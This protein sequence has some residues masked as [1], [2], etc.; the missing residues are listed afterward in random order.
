MT[1]PAK[2]IVSVTPSVL[3]AAGQGLEMNGVILTQ[4]PQVPYAAMQPFS[5]A[6][7][8]SEYFG[9]SSQEAALAQNYFAGFSGSNIKPGRL[10]FTQYNEEAVGAYLRGGDARGYSLAQLQAL[11]G[12]LTV[13][14]DGATRTAPSINLSGASS[15]SNAASIIQTALFATDPTEATASECTISGTTM[16][17]GGTITGTVEVGQTVTGSG[18]TANTIILSQISGTPGGAG[19]Y[20]VSQTQTVGSPTAFTMTA[21]DG[22]V[23]FDS[24]SGGFVVSSGITGEPSTIGFATGTIAAA[25]FLT[26]ATG[27]V[28]SQGA[29]AASPAEFMSMLTGISQ[30][31]ATFMTAFDPD[32][33]SGNAVKKAFADWNSLQ[34]NRWCYVCWDNDTSPLN[35]VP[36]SASLG[37]LL[38]DNA[39]SG[40]VLIYDDAT[41]AKKAAFVCGTIASIDFEQLNGRITLS[42]KHQAGLEQTLLSETEAQNLIDNHY[43]FYSEYATA[44]DEFIWFYPGQ[45][46][47]EY[48]WA[49]AY[50]NQIAMNNDFQLS[51]MLLLDQVKAVPYNAAGRQLIEAAVQGTINKYLNFGAFSPGVN[52][53]PLQIA[54]VNNAAGVDLES[55]LYTQGYYFQVLPASPEAR[56]RRTT[57]PC[58]FWYC[59]AG[60]VQQINLASIM[61]Q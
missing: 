43:N 14:I 19:D 7:D 38:A 9:P 4:N 6:A 16:T 15:F 27:A 41:D 2:A 1:I 55:V 49:D 45:I 61:L 60:A 23:T 47:G 57:P 5:S 52:L 54:E 37:Q 3:A 39:S 51:L 44:N 33:G 11:T 28:T 29:D 42:F 10:Y 50:V 8:V 26:A 53:S 22:T 13:V 48:A 36:A 56:A 30:N 58:T 25:L 59:D 31:W 12:S 32:G 35:T 18:V 34:N 24:V 17:V 46:M 40:T 21:T 20:E